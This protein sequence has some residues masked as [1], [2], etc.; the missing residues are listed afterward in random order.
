MYLVL[1]KES[2]FSS[3]YNVTT[4]FLV[5]MLNNSFRL[6]KMKQESLYLGTKLS[7][8]GIF[9]LTFE[10]KNIVIIEATSNFSK[11]IKN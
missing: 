3:F 10:Q 8:L 1:I 11:R 7:Y 6:S 9:R 4:F 5:N 2:K